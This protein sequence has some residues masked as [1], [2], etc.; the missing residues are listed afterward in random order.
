MTGGTATV[1]GPVSP[2]IPWPTNAGGWPP[3]GPSPCAA[4]ETT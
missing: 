1:V 3:C 4:S 2:E